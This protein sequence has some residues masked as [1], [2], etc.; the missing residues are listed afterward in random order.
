MSGLEHTKDAG[1]F[2]RLIKIIIQ[3]AAP[4]RQAKHGQRSGDEQTEYPEKR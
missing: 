1:A 4:N 2:L 3:V